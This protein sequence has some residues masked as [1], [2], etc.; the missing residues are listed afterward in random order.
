MADFSLGGLLGG[1]GGLY[2]D[3]LTPQ[4]QG[5]L[6]SRG[7]LAMAGAFADAGMPSRLPIP[8]GAAMGTG[9]D[10][11][12]LQVLQGQKLAQEVQSLKSQLAIRQQ[13]MSQ[14]PQLTQDTPG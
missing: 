3:L 12:A 13:L 11:A 1:G 7:L 2:D 9:R 14:L 6:S 5:Q 10:Q 4:Q 8:L